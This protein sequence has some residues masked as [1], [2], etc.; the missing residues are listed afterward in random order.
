MYQTFIKPLAQDVKSFVLDVLFPVSCLSCE[1]EGEF[2]CADC[3]AILTK[4]ENQR[5]IACQKA[6]PFGLT[7]PG[8][9]T[10]QSADG[11]ISF[12]D[13]RDEKVAK[14]IIGGKY[15]FIPTAYT[16]LGAMI[17]NK[18]KIQHEHL[19]SIPYALTPIPLH[20]SRKRWRG[21][22][23]ADVLCQALSKELALPILDPLIRN[24]ITQT[25][26]DLKKEQRIKNVSDAFR[27]K[28]GADVKGKNLIL[29]DD[30]TTTGATLQEAAKILKRNGA[31][32]VICLTVARD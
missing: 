5:C 26:K 8:C 14:V 21:F 32:K 12:Y 11:L 13:Y 20:P 29:V 24:K 17:A 23:Q 27:L 10:P 1:A 28:P 25:Q 15:S 19:L 3:K 4:L 7:H 18:I 30:V 22:N 6:T 16:I 2:I 31:A 9:L